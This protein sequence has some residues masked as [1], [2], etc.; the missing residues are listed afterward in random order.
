M[1]WLLTLIV[2]ASHKDIFWFWIL[3]QTLILW[4]NAGI[5]FHFS[6]TMEKVNAELRYWC[7]LDICQLSTNR[8]RKMVTLT[9]QLMNCYNVQW[10]TIVDLFI[11]WSSDANL[12]CVFLSL[13]CFYELFISEKNDKSEDKLSL[14]IERVWSPE[15]HYQTLHESII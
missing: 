7:R 1:F 11:V 3:L 2:K 6:E 13:H 8:S 10:K 14:K 9:F 12:D 4:M 15:F 5:T